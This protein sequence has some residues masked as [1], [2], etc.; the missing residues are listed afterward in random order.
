MCFIIIDKEIDEQNQNE[1]VSPSPIRAF[2]SRRFQKMPPKRKTK[3]KG[4]RDSEKEKSHWL[5]DSKKMSMRKKIQRKFKI[6]GYSLKID[7][8][9]SIL[10]FAD[11]FPGDDE[12]EAIDL[13]LDQLQT[14]N[15][16]LLRLS[17]LIRFSYTNLDSFFLCRFFRTRCGISS[18]RDWS[19]VRS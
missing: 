4:L 11:Q 3:Q 18:R 17:H 5:I 13:L 6:R 14:E 7:A 16:M 9:N 19:F 10:A 8:L 12:G 15:R 2:I 1:K